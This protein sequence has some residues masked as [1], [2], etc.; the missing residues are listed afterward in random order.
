LLWRHRR[1]EL[2]IVVQVVLGVAL[3]PSTTTGGA[4]PRLHGF[5][6][7]ATIGIIYATA[8]SPR[9]LPAYGPGGLFL[10]GLAPAIVISPIPP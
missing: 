10:M 1:A 3:A 7:L 2:T 5:V 6:A 8:T 4:V 9:P